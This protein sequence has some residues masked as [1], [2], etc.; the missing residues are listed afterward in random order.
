VTFATRLA[1]SRPRPDP[2]IGSIRPKDIRRRGRV[3]G[4]DV[5]AVM[6][7]TAVAVIVG[8]RAPKQ[9]HST[10]PD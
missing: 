7:I 1:E 6:R 2:P 4:I 9:L 8:G 5:K 3:S 10:P